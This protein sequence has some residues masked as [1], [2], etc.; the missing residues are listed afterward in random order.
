M[1]EQARKYA[2]NIPTAVT[3][4]TGVL[5]L[6]SAAYGLY[7]SFSGLLW[8]LQGAFPE[9]TQQFVYF[10]PAV[11]SMLSV[12]IVCCLVLAWCGLDQ[13]R[14]RLAH[15][16]LFIGLFV[17]EI[18]YLG[19][20]GSFLWPLP[21]IWMSVGAASGV[22]VD[23]LIPPFRILLPL[24]APFALAWAKKRLTNSAL[25]HLAE[26]LQTGAAGR[27]ETTSGRMIRGKLLKALVGGVGG[28]ISF[29]LVLSAAM[30]VLNEHM[31]AF[32]FYVAAFCLGGLCVVYSTMLDS[33]I[34]QRTRGW[35]YVPIAL[36]VFASYLAA[37]LR[38]QN[39]SIFSL[40][41]MALSI[42][43]ILNGFS[44]RA[45]RNCLAAFAGSVFGIVALA[46]GLWASA[47]SVLG[48]VSVAEV[49][50]ILDHPLVLYIKHGVMW[51]GFTLGLL[52]SQSPLQKARETDNSQ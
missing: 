50:G 7:L 45:L 2:M 42:G 38:L 31:P 41:P 4:G 19:F 22:A 40:F 1:A 27:G 6:L 35:Y 12:T 3:V 8:V 48:I 37:G 15:L 24:W 44:L 26:P 13:V 21:N 17:F 23:G 11:Y 16:K 30:S 10:Y 25:G 28:G 34:A 9:V 14:L 18:L 52:L 39:L 33:P 49:K 5:T 43:I 29:F 20:I 47:G 46:F 36:L 51:Y 32:V